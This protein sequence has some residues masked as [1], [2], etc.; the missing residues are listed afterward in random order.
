MVD[1]EGRI[2]GELFDGGA[3]KDMPVEIGA[4]Q[5]LA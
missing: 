5:M 1:F 3:G 4:G 2:D